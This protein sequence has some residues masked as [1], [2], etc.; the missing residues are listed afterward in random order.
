MVMNELAIKESQSDE[1]VLELIVKKK[2]KFFDTHKKLILKMNDEME[3]KSLK[4]LLNY[5]K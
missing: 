5:L 1:S 4:L 3:K 2:G